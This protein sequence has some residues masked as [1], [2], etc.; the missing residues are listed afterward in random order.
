MVVGV[1]SLVDD[2]NGRHLVLGLSVLIASSN[3]KPGL[4]KN[5]TV[6]LGPA[7]AILFNCR[8]ANVCRPS[9]LLYFFTYSDI[10]LPQQ[11]ITT[12]HFTKRIP[13]GSSST[14]SYTFLSSRVSVFRRIKA[15]KIDAPKAMNP[16]YRMAGLYALIPASSP[17]EASRM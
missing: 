13:A 15:A 14:I 1:S 7:P 12:I 8:L 6:L 5:L 4:T 17:P 9:R 3:G 2:T 10:V 11:T 16:A